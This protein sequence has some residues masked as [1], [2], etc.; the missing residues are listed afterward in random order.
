MESKKRF[1]IIG[2]AGYVAPRHLQAIGALGHE[3][4]AAH[5]LSDSVGVM[6]RYFPGLMKVM[7]NGVS[8][9]D[10]IEEAENPHD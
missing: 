5:D 6:D 3:L 10:A 2:V 1:A 8:P 4:V 9:A 7:Y